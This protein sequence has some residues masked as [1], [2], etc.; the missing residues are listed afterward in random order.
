MR[1]ENRNFDFSARDEI[2]A[3]EFVEKFIVIIETRQHVV[4]AR[5]RNGG[6]AA[7]AFTFKARG[8]R[9]PFGGSLLYS[10]A[11]LERGLE[12]RWTGRLGSGQILR[13]DLHR[14]IGRKTEIS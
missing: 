13:L 12:Q 2:V 5:K 1:G 11:V 6:P 8:A 10:N 4:L 9:F 7:A 3:H 14:R